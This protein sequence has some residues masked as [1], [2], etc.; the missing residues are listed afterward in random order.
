MRLIHLLVIGALVCAAAFV[1][2]IKMDSS[3]VVELNELLPG[4]YTATV[5]DPRLV[6]LGISARTATLRFTAARD[7]TKEA[8]VEIE[9]ADDF[10]R[11]RCAS[12][13]SAANRAWIL[14]RVVTA[15]GRPEK[16]ARWSIRDE[17]GATLVE[18]GRVDAD[19]MFQ[20][21]RLPMNSRVTVDVWRDT[22]RASA[23]R[24]VMEPL[25]TLHFVLQ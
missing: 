9:T 21:C 20:W 5:R 13:A 24:I 11:R 3:G 4:P 7:S 14:G 25:T 6:A 18:D 19:G 16:E 8:L 15:D 1:Y 12:E 23:S 2:Q 10:V 17:F 22:R